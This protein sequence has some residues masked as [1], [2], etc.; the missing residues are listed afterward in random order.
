MKKL[1][2]I[3]IYLFVSFEVKSESDDFGGKKLLC[4]D[5]ISINETFSIVGFEF[6]VRE[7]TFYQLYTTSGVFNVFRGKYKNNPQTITF[8]F[9]GL[10]NFLLE[11]DRQNLTVNLQG[12]GSPL[13]RC[14]LF[15][16][17]IEIYFKNLQTKIKNGFKSN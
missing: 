15:N 17:D 6:S 5:S 4:N 12:D 3:L 1:L 10:D 14:E 13:Y 2:F 9:S 11:L 8:S 16:G 7:M